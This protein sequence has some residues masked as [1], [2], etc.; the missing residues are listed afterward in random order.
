KASQK[1]GSLS[2]ETFKRLERGLHLSAKKVRQMMT[3]RSEIYGIEVSTPAEE[4]LERLL[5]SPYSRV[6]IYRESFDQ[7]LGAVNIKDVASWLAIR[8]QIPPLLAI[9]RPMPYVPD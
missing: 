8:G 1:G 7:V 2:P 4:V 3:P 5:L 6:P 9:L